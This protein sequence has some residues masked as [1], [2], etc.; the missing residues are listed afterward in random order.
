MAT[1]SLPETPNEILDLIFVHLDTGDLRFLSVTCR[2]FHESAEKALCAKPITLVASIKCDV[3][4]LC[5][6]LRGVITKPALGNQVQELSV[7]FHGFSSMTF[8]NKIR[9]SSVEARMDASVDFD[10]TSA[11]EIIRQDGQLF[12]TSLHDHGL[13]FSFSS[14]HGNYITFH[15][16]LVLLLAHLPNL[17]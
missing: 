5:T 12:E 1:F 15:V 7:S 2:G 3:R 10:P 11:H 6:L 8:E 4:K 13:K 17:R 9:P 16:L 14:H